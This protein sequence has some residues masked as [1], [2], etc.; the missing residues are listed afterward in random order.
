MEFDV[1]V[2]GG[3]P[4][5]TVAARC[6]ASWGRSVVLFERSLYDATRYGETLP[7]EA[8]PLLARL[9]VDDYVAAVHAL[10][11]P[12]TVSAWGDLEPVESD[13]VR[14]PHGPGRHVDRAAFDRALAR[15]A[16][17]AGTHVVAGADVG[18]VAAG[19]DG[20]WTVGSGPAQVR[21][22]FVIDA[23][24][25]NGHVVLRR[26]T[27]RS[28]TLLALT[29]LLRHRP[30]RPPDLRTYVESTPRGWWYSAPVRE[31]ETVAMLFTD[32]AEYAQGLDLR[33]ELESAPLTR[34]R[35]EGTDVL[36][37]R[38]LTARSGLREPIAGDAWLAA[39]D[40]AASYDP[41]SGSGV[42]KAL[43]QGA[44]AAEAV[45]RRLRGE[46]GSVEAY[47]ARIRADFNAYAWT[48]RSTYAAER[49][50]GEDGFWGRRATAASWITPAL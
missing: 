29:L 18:R 30:N 50:W 16:A 31:Q 45:H 46:A 42:H 14:S 1:A 38:V 28:D 47:G 2:V 24:G 15:A 25:R 11:S 37:Q 8:T 17:D 34:G 12:G 33:D 41:V 20:R 22:R 26:R 4:A 40:S 39:G 23:A 5:G 21:A 48:R 27:V 43:A 13:F 32:R 3:G 36:D 44:L 9:G 7:P 49:R 10:P 6:L 35:L 19:R